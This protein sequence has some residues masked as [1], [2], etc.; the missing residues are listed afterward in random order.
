MPHK[1]QLHNKCYFSTLLEQDVP[2]EWCIHLVFQLNFA[3]GL[4]RKMKFP[5]SCTW[6]QKVPEI[7]HGVHVIICMQ[8]QDKAML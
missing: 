8:L 5:V 1:H 3:L 7:F 6:L 4:K 2:F